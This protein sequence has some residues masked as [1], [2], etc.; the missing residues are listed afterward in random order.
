M[1][2]K[3]G[4][5]TLDVIS[6]ADKFNRWM[7]QAIQP[8]AKGDILEIGSGIGNIS[9]HVLENNFQLM[10]S[11]FR[12]EYCEELRNKFST[13][14]NILGVRRIDLV[15]PEFSQK[16]NDLL[17]KFDTVFALNVIEHI[18]DDNLAIANCKRFLRKGGH[19]IILVPSY[20]KLFN[21]FDVEL[22]HFRRYN[23]PKLINIFKK[24]ELE[25]I[26]HQYFNL[27]GTLGWLVNGNLLKKKSIPEG[28][29]ILYNK[30]VPVFK[31]VDK[32][33]FNKVGLSTIVIGSRIY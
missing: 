8:F 31:I 18:E 25:I 30:L 4:R 22:G 28:Q 1:E 3:V 27:I 26:H 15:D 7:F 5:G 9:S 16:Y 24:N 33:A 29:M 21:N 10:L 11:D 17:N 12:S 19:L 23:I 20:Q 13:Y 2:D 14:P 6:V 32:A